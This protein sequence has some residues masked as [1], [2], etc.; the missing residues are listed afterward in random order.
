VS[1]RFCRCL[2]LTLL[3]LMVHSAAAAAATELKSG[4]RGW[5]PCGRTWQRAAETNA[6][7]EPT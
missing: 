3:V 7:V 2:V 1:R 4:A 5:P 6:A